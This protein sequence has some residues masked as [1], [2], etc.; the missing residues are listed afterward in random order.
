MFELFI[1]II[2]LFTVLKI[3]SMILI[4]IGSHQEKKQVQGGFEGFLTRKNITN[5][6]YIFTA[7]N[8]Y[9]VHDRGNQKFWI[10]S[11][12]VVGRKYESIKEVELKIDDTVTYQSSLGSAVGRAIVG[13]VVAGGVG[14]VI[15][16]VT[17]KKTGK[18]VVHSIELIISYRNNNSTSANR[19]PYSKVSF[20][21]SEQGVDVVSDQFKRA[22]EEAVYWSNLIS[23]VIVD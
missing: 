5:Y 6:Q 23:S 12:K 22:E 15:G 9:L 16:G 13:G 14:A 20:L 8:K 17:G 3:A 1:I 19:A 4:G 10:Y 7:D 2:V 18:K 11:G 21:N